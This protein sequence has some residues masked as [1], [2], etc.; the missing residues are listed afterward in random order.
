MITTTTYNIDGR[1]IKNYS[2]IVAGETIMGANIL[3][4]IM[5][6]ITDVIGGRSNAYEKKLA[7]AREIAMKEM[8]DDARAQGADAVVGVAFNYQTLGKSMLMV[9]V[10]G[11]AVILEKI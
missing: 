7:Q 5:A 10:T 8:I 4:D 1:T 2:G 11:T 6:S 9:S 3:R